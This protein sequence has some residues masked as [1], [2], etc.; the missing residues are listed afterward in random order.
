[1]VELHLQTHVAER[2]L[3]HVTH[4]PETV[5]RVRAVDDAGVG[6]KG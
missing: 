4:Q 6:R 1:M 5:F 2:I 3:L